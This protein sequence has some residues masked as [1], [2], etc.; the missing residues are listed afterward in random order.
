MST[1]GFL[2]KCAF[3]LITPG[4]QEYVTVY[5]GCLFFDVQLI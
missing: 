3:G 5:F 2:L 1:L 4:Y